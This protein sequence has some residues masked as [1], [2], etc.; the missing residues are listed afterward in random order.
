MRGMRLTPSAPHVFRGWLVR[1]L[2]LVALCVCSHGCG[3]TTPAI[4]DMPPEMSPDAS[5]A[6]AAKPERIPRS[7]S[8]LAI[9]NSYSGNATSYLKTIAAAAGDEVV[10]GLAVTA[11]APLDRHARRVKLDRDDP[12]HPLGHPY[13]ARYLPGYPAT[14]GDPE[15]I[16]LRDALTYRDWDVVTIQQASYKSFKSETLEPYATEL[17][18]LIRETNP[19]ARILIHQTWAY[20]IDANRLANWG[21]T[22]KQMHDGLVTS[23]DFLSLQHRL[24]QIPV[25]D[26]FAL[27]RTT[28]DWSYRVDETYSFENPGP[29]TLPDQSGSLNFGYNWRTDRE[30]GEPVLVL[31]AS[32]TNFAG[33]YLASCVWYAVLFDADPR[34]AASFTPSKLTAE[35]A[36]SLRE[37]A[38]DAVVA[39]QRWAASLE[40]PRFGW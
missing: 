15:K 30:T 35:Q 19:D 3:T 28:P 22:Q 33:S 26:A 18:A 5:P 21:M 38:H 10:L 27:A 34:A 12:S 8:V 14:D 31:D 7:L 11:G 36:A 37:I 25:G 4:R 2:G 6:E 13:P 17:I 40:N 16:S 20:R 39:E 1:S 23:Y 29:E 32:H 24:P 9:G